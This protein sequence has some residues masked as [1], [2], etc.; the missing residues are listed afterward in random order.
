M[1]KKRT[2]LQRL[3]ML[4]VF[5]TSLLGNQL[6]AQDRLLTGTVMDESTSE[7]LPGTSVII[8]GTSTGTITDLDGKFQLNVADGQTVVVSYVG[9]LAEEI[10]ISGQTSLSVKLMPDL[11]ELEQIVV[12]GYGTQKKKEVTGA[13]ASVKTDD[14][15]KVA[16]SDFTK[17]LQGQVAGVNVTEASGRPGA[18]ANVQIRGLGSISSAST[19]LYVIDGIP[20]SG[21]YQEKG[22]TYNTSPSIAAE[23]IASVDI[24]KDGAAAAIYGT[25]ASN[26]VILITTKRGKAGTTKVSLSS[27]YGFQN[28][29]SG[30]P[31]MNTAEH[32][33]VDEQ[34]QLG[35][36]LHS[37]ILRYNPDALDN[38]TDFVEAVSNNNAPMQTHNLTLS[39]GEKDLTF[40]FNTNYYEQ[41]GVLIHSGFDRLT[42]R[43]NA[44]YKKGKF[45]AF[46]SMNTLNSSTQQEPY[47]VYEYAIFNGPYRNP[48]G[49][50]DA[51][52]E[53]VHYSGQNPDHVG[54]LTRELINSDVRET[55]SYGLSTNLKYEILSGLTYQ[56]NI[57]YN[58]Q[59]YLREFHEPKILIWGEGAVEPNPLVSR[60]DARLTKE[61]QLNTK[62]T[63]EQVA[64]YNKSF[65]SHS[66][67]LTLGQTYEEAYFLADQSIKSTFSSN[68]LTNFDA[69]SVPVSIGGNETVNTLFGFIARGQYNYAERYLVSA[70][71]RRDGSSKFNE[72]NR[73]ANFPGV[74]V[75]W[76]MSE[77]SFMKSIAII[78]NLKLRLSYGEVGNEGIPPY[79]YSAYIYPNVNYVFGPEA[80]Y[81]V[82]SGSVQRAYGNP[83]VVWETNISRN[84]GADLAMFDN[85]FTFN[86]ELYQNTKED[87]LLSV[88]LPPSTGTTVPHDYNGIFH[89]KIANVG[90]MENK[91]IE[92]ASSYKYLSQQGLGLTISGTFTKNINKVT[93]LGDNLQEIPITQSVPAQWREPQQDITTYM[94]PGYAAGSF[95]LIPTDGII[96]DSATLEQVRTYMPLAEMGDVKY[97]DVNGDSLINDDDRQ[98]A[99]SPFPKFEAGM[100]FNADYKG[101]SLSVQLVY[102][103][104]NKVFNGN[105]MWA[106]GCG[107]HKDLYYMW[108][109]QNPDSDIP[110]SRINSEHNNFRSRTDYFLEDGSFLR[111]RNVTLGYTLPKSWFKDKVDKVEVYLNATNPLTFTKYEGY[112]PEV[113]G[114]GSTTRGIDRGSYP[115]SRKFLAGVRVD[116]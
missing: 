52:G 3:L 40:S 89:S 23:D 79:L 103:Y 85:K 2:N 24:L 29:T 41:E 83:E 1:K 71:F 63:F 54:Y 60:P 8:K 74:S 14:L 70:S 15:N 48:L 17:S 113:G 30:T 75:G 114:N 91:G 72:N 81:N 78:N 105:K 96:K 65:G 69:G 9:Y 90:D 33:Y 59:N 39:G 100:V 92:L 76:N 45:D 20:Y 99:G 26:G 47:A 101:I 38:N 80:T 7:P 51:I 116:F 53:E 84:F 82:A 10:A 67:T 95:F 31:L 43:L 58:S 37:T 4:A 112:D 77:E 16:V 94:K 13:V 5:L 88:V 56:I 108:T 27:Q 50:I 68:E 42:T 64:N 11:T 66:M 61:Y 22:L 97:I 98:Y 25:R 111:V 109:P 36:A 19:P 12:I 18:A 21:S 102:F 86:L 55:R 44:T 28:I 93:S 73:F 32:I 107:R 49:D 115:I 87:M 57:G 35:N 104:G 62:T 106:Y 46:I 110:A 34:R 6:F